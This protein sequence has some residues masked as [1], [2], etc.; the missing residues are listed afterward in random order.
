[1]PKK[2]KPAFVGERHHGFSSIHAIRMSFYCFVVPHQIFRLKYVE[3]LFS[4]FS[5]N[6]LPFFIL[7]LSSK[8]LFFTVI[9]ETK[10]E[11]DSIIERGQ[12][13]VESIEFKNVW[14]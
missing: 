1:M 12:I 14:I 4:Q 13:K 3:T 6:F 8:L 5:W 7:F 11:Y 2:S 9:P 10:E